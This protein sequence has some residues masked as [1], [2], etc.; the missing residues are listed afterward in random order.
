ML[1]IRRKEFIFMIF[2]CNECGSN[3]MLDIEGSG[4]D[5]YGEFQ[6]YWCMDCDALSRLYY[7]TDDLT[8]EEVKQE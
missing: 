7:E 2:K 1:N 4:V 6:D 8:I 3:E 5:I